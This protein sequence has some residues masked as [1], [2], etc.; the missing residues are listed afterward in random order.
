[1]SEFR[2]EISEVCKKYLFQ[3][4]AIFIMFSFLFTCVLCLSI[5]IVILSK[6]NILEWWIIVLIILAALVSCVL[7]TVSPYIYKAKTLKSFTPKS[8]KI[9]KE[10]ICAEFENEYMNKSMD[11][12]KK[13]YD[14][15]EWY[16]VVLKFP[17]LANLVCQKDL[18]IN[19]SIEEFEKLFFNKIKRK[20]K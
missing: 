7:A 5:I 10:E 14:L 16:Y 20:R 18:L 2:C 9:D 4:L 17:K 6:L 1:M 11:E 3:K 8:I 12:V 13:V 19:G 15:G